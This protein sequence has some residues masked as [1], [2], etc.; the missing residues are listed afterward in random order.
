MT[1]SEN[2]QA[3]LLLTAR[4]PK[5]RH[6]AVK[7]LTA[8][9]WGRF[10]A[11]M[12]ERALIP[13]SLLSS[14]PAELLKDWSDNQ[15]TC[16]RIEALLNRGPAL[17]LAMNRW[18]G[19]GLWVITRSDP[20]YPASLKRKLGKTSPA[21]LFGCGNRTLLSGGGLA[22]VG[23]RN[24]TDADL[25]Y[26]RSIGSI[27]ASQ[28]HTVISGGARGIDEAAMQGA[29]RSEGT[30]VGV[31]ANNLLSQCT[32]AK[33]RPHV[34]AN[35]LVLFSTVHPEAPFLAGSAMQRNKYIYCLSDAALVVHS[36]TKGGTW[37]GAIDNLK[38]RWTPLWVRK[39]TDPDSGNT[40]LAKRGAS[41]LAC[42]VNGIRIDRLF[43]SSESA[44]ALF[45]QPALEAPGSAATPVLSSEAAADA[46]AS[47]RD[48]SPIARG[49]GPAPNAGIDSAVCDPNDPVSIS[50][51]LGGASKNDVLHGQSATQN[52]E[53]TKDRFYSLFLRELR[54][55]SSEKPIR[56]RELEDAF[57][58]ASSQL[59]AWLKR[60]ET[61]RNVKKLNRPVRYLWITEARR[62]LFDE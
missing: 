8:S 60:A 44:P 29:M 23:S 50:S 26:A 28:G 1:V 9:E 3:I 32:S 16:S 18:L 11:W 13:E 52:S 61:D 51:G 39:G 4:F 55:V 34:R 10:A 45:S 17:A 40:V 19:A 53:D 21:V 37:S 35:D 47:L 5:S 62:T 27:A 42:N 20:D 36:G 14:R 24:A 43:R 22:V 49:S 15:V 54:L 30:V 58:L 2:T 25:R 46:M 31:L 33:Y 6:E 41:L 12:N 59:K 48:E 56:P 38:S 7:P 57:D